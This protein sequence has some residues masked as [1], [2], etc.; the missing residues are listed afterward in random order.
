MFSADLT[1]SIRSVAAAIN[2]FTAWYH[3]QFWSPKIDVASMTRG[4]NFN[5]PHQVHENKKRKVI[6]VCILKGIF[7][8]ILFNLILL[9]CY[10][11]L[12]FILI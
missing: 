5:A 6:D 3:Q 4:V 7:N 12:S 8:C 10:L 9:S 1:D 2:I 11:Y